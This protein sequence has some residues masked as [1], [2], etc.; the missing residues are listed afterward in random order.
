MLQAQVVQL[1]RL[2]H[3]VLVCCCFYEI[4]SASCSCVLG[5]LIP[6]LLYPAVIPGGSG[7]FC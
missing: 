2:R 3:K 6:S 4:H 7:G 1:L 5:L